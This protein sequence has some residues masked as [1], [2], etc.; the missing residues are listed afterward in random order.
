MGDTYRL[1]AGMANH[2]DRAVVDEGYGLRRALTDADIPL[3]IGDGNGDHV[4]GR[5]PPVSHLE[6][7]RPTGAGTSEIRRMP[8]GRELATGI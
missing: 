7:T 8:I 1:V 4:L 2:R 3:S 6:N 5:A